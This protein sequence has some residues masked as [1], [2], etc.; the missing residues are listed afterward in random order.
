LLNN[1]YIDGKEGHG[2]EFIIQWEVP[3][4]WHSHPMHFEVYQRPMCR[5]PHSASQNDTFSRYLFKSIHCVHPCY[6]Q[7]EQ[8]IKSKTLK[9]PLPQKL[10]TKLATDCP[11]KG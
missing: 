3:D 11:F 7:E 10:T 9:R 4:Q 6:L 8:T 5:D 2:K 1:H